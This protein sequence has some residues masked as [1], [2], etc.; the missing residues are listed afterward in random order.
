MDKIFGGISNKTDGI[1]WLENIVHPDDKKKVVEEMQ[2]YIRDNKK[3][4]KS[5]YRVLSN[6]GDW[7]W[8]LVSGKSVEIDSNN[9]SIIS[10]IL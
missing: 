4:Y 3:I 8:I 9:N 6:N 5:E 2:N 7:K 10:I 1:N